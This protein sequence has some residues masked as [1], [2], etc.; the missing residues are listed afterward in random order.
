MSFA[1]RITLLL[2][3]ALYILAIYLVIKAFAPSKRRPIDWYLEKHRLDIVGGQSD[4]G[5]VIK[6]SNELTEKQFHA[7]VKACSQYFSH[8][9]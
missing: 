3:Y 1:D 5:F 4:A 8:R 7:L 9:E 6:T 2:Q